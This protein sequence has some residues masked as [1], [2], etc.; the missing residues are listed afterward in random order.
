MLFAAS[1]LLFTILEGFIFIYAFALL[2]GYKE[3][4]KKNIIRLLLSVLVY[5]TYTY[6]ISYFMPLG[7]HTILISLL[8]VILLNFTFNSAIFKTII[9][10]FIIFIAISIIET[11]IS[12]CG[13][14]ITNIPINE[15]LQNDYYILIC[16]IIAKVIELMCILI[17]RKYSYN[18]SWLNDN[19]PVRSRYKSVL[20][21]IST[22]IA[23]MIATNVYLTSSL[24]KAFIFNIFTFFIYL[25]LIFAIVSAFREGSKLELLQYANE[26]QKEN[27][28]Q[29]IDFNEMVAKERHEYKNHL[30]TIFGLCTLDKP[31]TNERIKHYIN[32]YANN[33]ST[34]NIS[35]D[36]GNDLVDA[37]IN[38]KYNNGLR[39][40]IE[41]K[42]DFEAPLPSAD[43]QEDVAVTILSNIIENA[44]EAMN[45]IIKD[46]KFVFL[47]T[48]VQNDLYF[49]SISNNGPMISEV[50]KIKIF[51]AGYSTKD[52][53]SKA[54]GFGLSIVQNEINRCNG[55]IEINSTPELT[56]FL[57]SF[58][59]KQVQAAV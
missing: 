55:S 25:I 42:A 9:K 2:S 53:P 8:T 33:S 16:S 52:N 37:V 30:N 13:L 22:A 15:L 26:M 49:I 44:F 32:N 10:T 45:N 50:D 4:H 29:L 54:R 46:N 59:L 18:V 23:F 36:S 57:V 27:I 43:I 31:D 35:I 40:G 21:L 41:L 48:Y 7:F 38:V 3:Y 51:N 14:V 19:T 12:I 24:E 6:W 11:L 39:K 1:E 28:Q 5:T 47:R 17:M 34:K 58:D 20:V 56:E